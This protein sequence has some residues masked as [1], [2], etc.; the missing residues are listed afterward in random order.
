MPRHTLNAFSMFPYFTKANAKTEEQKRL[1]GLLYAVKHGA[2]IRDTNGDVAAGDWFVGMLRAALAQGV[3]PAEFLGQ[4]V[5]LVPMPSSS[6]TDTPPST[7]AWPMFDLV[8][9]VA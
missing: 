8:T 1:Q 5:F 7:S 3:L 4:R 6:V 9:R 2:Q